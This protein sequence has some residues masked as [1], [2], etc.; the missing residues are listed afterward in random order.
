MPP[1][2]SESKLILELGALGDRQLAPV[3]LPSP[4]APESTMLDAAI[5]PRQSSPSGEKSPLNES[6]PPP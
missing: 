1:V 3:T 5:P 4:T 6:P 2:G